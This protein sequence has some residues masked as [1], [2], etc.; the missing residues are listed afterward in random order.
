MKQHFH[1]WNR[2]D[3]YCKLR[4]GIDVVEFNHDDYNN[5]VFYYPN[6]MYRMELNRNHHLGGPYAKVYVKNGLGG[7]YFEAE[8][9]DEWFEVVKV[10]KN[11]PKTI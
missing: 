8:D 4:S 11:F 1:E 7:L 3:G 6:I 5:G 9:F 10:D 2:C